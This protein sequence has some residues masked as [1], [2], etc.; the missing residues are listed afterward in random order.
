M[1]YYLIDKTIDYFIEDLTNIPRISPN[2]KSGVSIIDPKLFLN[3]KA[4]EILSKLG[5]LHCLIFEQYP[6]YNKGVIHLDLDT[7]LTPYWP[8]LNIILQGQ[9]VMRWFDPVCPGTLIDKGVGPYYKIWKDS[10]KGKILSEWNKGK[11]AIVRTDIPHQAYNYDES[12]RIAVSV[13]WSNRY[14]FDETITF[15]KDHFDV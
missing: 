2:Q 4:Y 6:F 8:C 13:R 10:L 15:F 11:I 5:Y 9:G 14:S 12:I 3:K 7:T 1:Y